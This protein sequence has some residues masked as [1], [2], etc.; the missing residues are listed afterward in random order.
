[1]K[2]KTN[3]FK[4]NGESY[5]KFYLTNNLKYYKLD[6]SNSFA[7]LMLNVIVYSAIIKS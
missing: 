3:I 6:I 5:L 4:E 7:N 2:E 1:M